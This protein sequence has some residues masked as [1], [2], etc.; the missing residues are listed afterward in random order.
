VCDDSY[1]TV[2]T[3]SA[4]IEMPTTWVYDQ[5]MFRKIPFTKVGRN[6]RFRRSEIEAWLAERSTPA[7][8]RLPRAKQRSA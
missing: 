2:K 1:F 8:E 7:V 3:L 6:L 5:V 4:Y